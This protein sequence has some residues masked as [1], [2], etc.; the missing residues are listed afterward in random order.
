M[1]VAEHLA[2]VGGVAGRRELERLVGRSA[3]AASVARGS[4]L[5]VA[6]G[7]YALPT[8]S[9]A[10]QAAGELTGTAVLLSAA[11]HWGWRTKWQ[12]ARPQVAVGLGRKVPPEVRSR[13]DVRWR[14]IPRVRRQV[15]I[16]DA[17]GWVGRVDLA[18]EDLRIVL[19]ADSLATC[20][21]SR[22]SSG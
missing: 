13:I 12:P 2:R 11:A 18:D 9:A 4:V 15:R 19:E 5:R 3:L 17:D 7:R 6:R 8:A 16:D 20:A 21:T 10:Q 14:S 22:R 1:D